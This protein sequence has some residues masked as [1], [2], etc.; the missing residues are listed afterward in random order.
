MEKLIGRETEKQL[1]DDVIRS[2]APE[3]IALYGRRRVG[4]T[5]LIRQ[6]LK[7][8]L[9]F[10]FVGSRDAKLRAQLENFKKAL[11]LA[12]GSD[13]LYQT[14]DSWADAF[15]QLSHYLTP[16]LAEGK[17]VVFLDEFPWLN[18][19]KSGFLSAFDHWW[20]SW[21]NKQDNLVVVICG[22]AASWMI[23]NVVNNKGGLH[24][25]ITRKIR[26]LPFSLGETEAFLRARNIHLDRYQILQLYMVMG[27]I[28]HYLKEVKKGESSIQAIDRICFTK[29]GILASEFKNLYHS[30][31]EDATRHLAVVRALAA[32]NSGLTRSEI[33]EKAGF[34]SGGTITGLLEELIESGFVT[35]WQPFDKK[36]K[37]LIYKLADEFTHFYL[38]FIEKNRSFGHG[39]WQS[40]SSGQSWKSWIG[41]AFERACL[42]HTLQLKKALGIAGVYT[43][44]SAWR[45]QPSK[46]KG[47]QI[48]LLLDRKDFVINLCE[49]KYSESTFLI[50]KGY[51]NDLESKRDV[52]KKQSKTKKSLFLTFIT[53]FGITDNEYAKRLIQN[54]ITM[55]ALYD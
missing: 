14:P 40:F 6:Y 50:D 13:K 1:L 3:L 27:G 54:S 48:D 37:D 39:V 45:Y 24:N 47:A 25:R 30:L 23:Q 11:G 5:F 4:K 33:I 31:F 53:T 43:E 2:G 44:E 34:T 49:M 41:V 28:P 9:V 18:S 21:G 15:S 35:A 51:A 26:L 7:S 36:S 29:D 16:K 32:N 46:G 42:K 38:K 19:H 8:S 20:N 10:E 52:F 22:S 55:D 17:S 12:I